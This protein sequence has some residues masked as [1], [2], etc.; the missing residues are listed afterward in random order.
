MSTQGKC[1]CI[2]NYLHKKYGFAQRAFIYVHR[3][4]E[5]RGLYIG[6]FYKN[7]K[8]ISFFISHKLDT[9]EIIKLTKYIDFNRYISMSLQQ[10]GHTYNLKYINFEIINFII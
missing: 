10:F 7:K 3:F 1:M 6:T 5:A 4:L 8:S 9:F 2:H